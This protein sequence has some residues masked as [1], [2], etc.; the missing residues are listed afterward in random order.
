M[1]FNPV[2]NFDGFETPVHS[3]AGYPLWRRERIDCLLRNRCIILTGK[4]YD[5]SVC[6]IYFEMS[7]FIFCMYFGRQSIK[8]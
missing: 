2:A 3:G 5:N 1:Y 7:E 6:D 4:F 8:R